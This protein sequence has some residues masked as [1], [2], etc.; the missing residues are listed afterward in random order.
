[1]SFR[2]SSVDLIMTGSIIIASATPPERAEKPPI[3]ITTHAYAIIPRIIEG[4]PMRISTAERI[5]WAIFL[6]LFSLKNTPVITP[7]GIAKQD[8]M[9]TNM[10]VP[11][12]AFEIPPPTSPTGLGS[13]A[14]NSQ[15]MALKPFTVM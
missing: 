1:M 15:L 3:G 7:I 11:T 13:D 9:M 6:F 14:I 2:V 8:A 5:T 12:I 4:M 10:S